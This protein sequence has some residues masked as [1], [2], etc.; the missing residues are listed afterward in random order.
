MAKP[1][2]EMVQSKQF[3]IISYFPHTTEK[4]SHGRPAVRN[5]ETRLF[6]HKPPAALTL[7][8]HLQVT[9]GCP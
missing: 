3:A 6:P 2:P 5:P 9:L 1:G 7:T 4:C 8:Q